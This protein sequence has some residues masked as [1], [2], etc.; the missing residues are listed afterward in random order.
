MK[1]KNINQRTE[2]AVA[3]PAGEEQ[4]KRKVSKQVRKLE[5]ELLEEIHAMIAKCSKL[6][7]DD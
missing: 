6:P 2:S 1:T 4:V 5:A 7:L 3:T